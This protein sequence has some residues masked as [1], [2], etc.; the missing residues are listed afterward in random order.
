MQL[1]KYNGILWHS[2]E[3]HGILCNIMVYHSIF[4]YIVVYL[5]IFWY[6]SSN[7]MIYHASSWC[8][9]AHTSHHSTWKHYLTYLFGSSRDSG[10]SQAA[11][12]APEEPGAPL[13]KSL[14]N[15]RS[16]DCELQ[17]TEKEKRVSWQI[18][19]R[20]T[21]IMLKGRIIWRTQTREYNC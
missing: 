6:L 14:R 9:M 2:I 7:I 13:M 18:K 11:K 10:C 8:F 16:F 21:L 17:E 5:Y 12:R 1:K 3:Y 20:N 19:R 4:C 15:C